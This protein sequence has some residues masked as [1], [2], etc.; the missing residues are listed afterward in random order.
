MTQISA[1]AV[2]QAGRFNPSESQASAPVG[3]LCGAAS[4]V[5]QTAN[6]G[7]E[8]AWRRRLPIPSP[9]PDSSAR[10]LRS[11]SEDHSGRARGPQPHRRPMPSAYS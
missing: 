8:K 5:V 2:A 6:P 4:P 9:S 10:R 1:G 3:T 7:R 11:L